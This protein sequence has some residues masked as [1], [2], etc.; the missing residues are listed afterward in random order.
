MSAVMVSRSAVVKFDWVPF[1]F[2][3]PTYTREDV[4]GIPGKK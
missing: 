4:T 1:D 3:E 2:V